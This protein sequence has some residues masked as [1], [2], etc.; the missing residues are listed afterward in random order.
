MTPLVVESY[1]T[2]QQNPGQTNLPTASNVRVNILWFLSLVF[3]LAT[4]VV[5]LVLLQ[6]LREHQRPR[7]GLDPR[8]AV[9][10]HHMRAEAMEEWYLPQIL[11]FLP[12]L[13]Q[14]AVIL[15]LIGLIDFLFRLNH[16]LAFPVTIAI[17]L[18]FSFLVVTSILPTLQNLM[19]FLPR[20]KPTATK[21]PRSPCAYKSVTSWIIH[22]LVASIVRFFMCFTGA[23][24]D[25]CGE[26]NPQDLFSPTSRKKWID[27]FPRASG[28]IFRKKLGDTWLEHEVG[29]L[30]QRDYDE[31]SRVPNSNVK[32][33]RPTKRPVPLYDIVMALQKSKETTLISQRGLIPSDFCVEQ[34]LHPDIIDC[35]PDIQYPALLRGLV[36]PQISYGLPD[37]IKDPANK[38]L[39]DRAN[40]ALIDHTMFH[41]L[42]RND[43]SDNMP[44]VLKRRLVEI[45]IRLTD[46]LHGDTEALHF[47]P[48]KT[49]VLTSLPIQ[50]VARQLKNETFDDLEGQCR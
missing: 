32:K 1:K 27:T 6:W 35:G 33:C 41:L 8:I 40:K 3:S 38:A 18:I 15:F 31:L 26:M 2:L 48:A 10:L 7:V 17:G 11:Y 4:A 5:G 47:D 45:C 28:F 29:W 36:H 25:Q 42:N 13:L 24:L 20:W 21:K 49:L 34:I 43:Q 23:Q 46:Y 12:F 44:K 19:L 16:M 30:F 39:K 50:W 9:A 22:Y 37:G 14:S